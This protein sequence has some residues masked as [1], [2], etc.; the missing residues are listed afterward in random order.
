MRIYCSIW[1]RSSPFLCILRACQTLCC[2]TVNLVTVKCNMR[3]IIACENK[4]F[5]VNIGLSLNYLVCAKRGKQYDNNNNSR[6]NKHVQS[7]AKLLA[8]LFDFLSFYSCYHNALEDILRWYSFT[9]KNP[10]SR[11]NLGIYSWIICSVQG[12]IS[13]LR[14]PDSIV[15]S[16]NLVN[17]IK[18]RTVALGDRSQE[19]LHQ[20]QVRLPFSYQLQWNSA[21]KTT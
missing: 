18:P 7:I 11:M 14:S 3:K 9:L 6:E 4:V 8:H 19:Q 16:I 20:R 1:T 21:I 13:L 12:W 5:Q 17:D 2:I 15:I 10:F